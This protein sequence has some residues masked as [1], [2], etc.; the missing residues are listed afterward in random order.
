VEARFPYVL[1]SDLRSAIT[2]PRENVKADK[3]VLNSGA[4][5]LAVP[6]HNRF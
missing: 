1:L 6:E 5:E 3:S 2:T 4:V